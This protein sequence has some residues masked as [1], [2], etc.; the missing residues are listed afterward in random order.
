MNAPRPEHSTIAAWEQL[1][2]L[3][4]DY[5]LL[6]SKLDTEG[7]HAA[8]VAFVTRTALQCA[9]TRD[10][11]ASGSIDLDLAL[12]IMTAA[13]ALFTPARDLVRQRLEQAN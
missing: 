7:A 9:A 2:K 12:D 6:T 3:A 1:D 13:T 5:R 11:I 8:D 10:Q 4:G